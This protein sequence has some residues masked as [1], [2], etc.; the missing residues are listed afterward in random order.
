MKAGDAVFLHLAATVDEPAHDITLVMYDCE[1]IE[2]SANSLGRIERELPDWLHA[3]VAILG[4]P[5]GG[6]I[7][8]GCQGT[9]RVVVTRQRHPRALGAI[10]VGRQRHSQAGRGARP[11]DG[12]RRPQR[13]HRRVHLP[14]GA[15]GGAHRRRHRRQRHP[16]RGVGHRQLPLRARPQHRAGRSTRARG[17]RRPRRAHRA[18]RR[19]PGRAARADQTRRRRTGR[20]RGRPGARESTAGPTWRDSLRWACLPSTSAPATPTSRT[21]PTSGSRSRQI[22]AATDMLRRYLTG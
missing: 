22:T 4:E 21:A 3:D 15:V 5:S 10:M 6:L 19:R 16:R 13:R 17:A 18:D 12:L 11:A 1:E 14:R 9:I 2:A 7:E 8:A 20:R